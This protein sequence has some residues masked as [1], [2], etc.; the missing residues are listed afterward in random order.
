[1]EAEDTNGDEK[2]N[3]VIAI[4]MPRYHTGNRTDSNNDNNNL[5]V[6]NWGEVPAYYSRRQE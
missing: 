6:G 2:V 3:M 5:L 1:M 4:S